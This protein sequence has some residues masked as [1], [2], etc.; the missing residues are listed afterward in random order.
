MFTSEH[1]DADQ[2]GLP[3]LP[4]ETLEVECMFA[5]EPS[6]SDDDAGVFTAKVLLIDQFGNRH[7]SRRIEFHSAG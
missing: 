6:P 3:L 4:G 5:V 7:V 1:R 2:G